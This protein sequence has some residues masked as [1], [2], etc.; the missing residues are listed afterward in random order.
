M[1]K[2]ILQL[3]SQIKCGRHHGRGLKYTRNGN[4]ELALNHFKT[5]LKFAL[6][7]GNDGI[8][9]L[10]MECVARTLVRIGDYGQAQKYANDSYHLYKK[11]QG[12][13]PVFDESIKRLEELLTLI[14]RRDILK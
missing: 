12:A 5:A 3:I 8:V 13:G 14:E 4:V 9:P 6:L 2:F 10:E 7:S 11:F 1:K